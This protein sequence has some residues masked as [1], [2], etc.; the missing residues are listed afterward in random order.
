VDAPAPTALKRKHEE[1]SEDSS[2]DDKGRKMQNTRVKNKPQNLIQTLLK[3]VA[4]STE[5]KRR[6]SP[7]QRVREEEIAIDP[8]F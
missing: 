3:V 2:N 6:S 5:Q 8:D 4:P 7:F 1:S